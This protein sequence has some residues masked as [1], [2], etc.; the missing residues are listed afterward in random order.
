[1]KSM[2][3]RKDAYEEVDLNEPKPDSLLQK[4]QLVMIGE[5]QSS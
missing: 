3:S 2:N 1:M 5:S 4:L